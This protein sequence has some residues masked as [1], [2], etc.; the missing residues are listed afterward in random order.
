MNKRFL[1]LLIFILSLFIGFVAINKAFAQFAGGV[2]V[3]PSVLEME[4]PDNSKTFATKVIQVEN[5]TNT[6][7]RVRA[8]IEGWT[9]NPYGSIVFSDKPDKNA[10]NDY[11]KFNPKEFDLAPGQ[12][13]MVRLASKL[14]AGNDGEYRSIIFFETVNP[15]QE[16]LNQA[17]D[18]L[19]I[20][21]SFKTRYGVAVYAY[22]GKVARKVDL[23]DLKFEKINN[24]NFVNATLKNNGN[25]HCNLE[26]ELSLIPE[27]T[28]DAV[29]VT[30]AKYTTLPSNTQKYRIQIPENLPVNGL[31]NA[32]LKLNYKD[33]E[34]KVQVL[35]AQTNFNYKSKA[36]Y[37]K[38]ELKKNV[39]NEE[40]INKTRDNIAKPIPVNSKYT[41]ADLNTEI[42]FKN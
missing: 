22:K 12:K 27:T 2:L 39:S 24:G 31:Y 8:Y 11:I 28:S 17:K 3:Y 38:K 19:N 16:I 34:G 18:K 37:T 21:V 40:N 10:L 30:L 33:E 4:F 29:K 35:E 14:P 32:V 23:Q 5:P 1:M 9:L 25:I 36:L 42:Q 7:L 20:N 6:P 15:K 26:G 41:P 13:Q